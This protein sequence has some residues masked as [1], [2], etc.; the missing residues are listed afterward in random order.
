MSP[1][2]LSH[3]LERLTIG[4]RTLEVASRKNPPEPPLRKGGTMSR[5]GPF[6]VPP[7]RESTEERRCIYTA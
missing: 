3:S 6:P 5:T 2:S 1:F 4:W 7:L